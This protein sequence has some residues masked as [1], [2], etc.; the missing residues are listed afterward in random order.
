M[1]S[2]FDTLGIPITKG[3]AFT[4]ADDGEA[5]PV[6]IV[7]ES[8]AERYWP[9]QNPIGR[10]VQFTAQFP[11]TTVV[12]VAAD[13]R[14]RQLTRDWLTVYFP[15]KQF[16]FFSPAVIVVRTATEPTPLLASLRRAVQAAAPA[17]AVQSVQTMGQLTSAEFARQ[18]TAV[19]I[20]TAFAFM[21]MLVAAIGIYAVSSY[22]VAQR[23]RELAVR[24]AIGASPAQ[25]LRGTL[26]DS[27]GLGVRGV[28]IGLL[29][30][31]L[32]TRVLAAMLFEVTHLDATSFAAA[33][34]G[35]LAIV[36]LASAVPA[37]RAGRVDP[38]LLLRSE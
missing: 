23:R 11:W 8:V 2:Y 36:V 15:A 10:R 37:R 26:R 17:A 1:P 13:T 29:A 27:L 34:A 9:G 12:G 30:A 25:I 19:I 22:E 20:A 38:A 5:A 35:L 4:N 33:G 21:A 24:A 18:R 7:S 3:R 16:F 31:S 32:V 28:V 6:A 14:Y